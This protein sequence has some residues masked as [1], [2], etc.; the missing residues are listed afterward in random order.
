MKSIS[1]K[2]KSWINLIVF[3]ITL[4]INYLTASGFIN[5]MSQKVVSNKYNTLITPAGF[6]FSIWGLIY[7]LIGISLV[8]MLLNNKETRVKSLINILTPIFLFNCLFNILWNISFL[9]EKIGLS[10]IFIFLML[11]NLIL[12]NKK[13]YNNKKEI[14]YKLTSL[15]FGIYAGWLT[16]ASFV[17][18]LAFLVSINW[19]GF[20]I[21][22]TIWAPI[23]LL[24]TIIIS[25]L[26][27][28]KL[29]N[30]VYLLP[31]AWA[32]FGI[33]MKINKS[34]NQ[35]IYRTYIIPLG[36][37]GIIILVLLSII[38]FKKNNYSVI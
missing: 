35:M 29:N 26:V 3:A 19:D 5:G 4:I 20:G 8:Y 18:M 12:I 23:I 25:I 11:V 9:Y 7:L 15:A 31:I 17:N 24:V 33:I 22:Q 38:K 36:I 10:T 6:T 2:V 32:I 13:L 34:D 16:I 1:T 28:M 30:S 27:N 37:I 21:S 14:K